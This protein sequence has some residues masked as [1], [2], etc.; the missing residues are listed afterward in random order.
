M[1]SVVP[2][3][4]HPRQLGGGAFQKTGRQVG[5]GGACDDGGLCSG[6]APLACV[7]ELDANRISEPGVVAWVSTR[8]RQ[9]A[10]GYNHRF[11]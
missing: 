3:A 6:K 5:G 1:R 4:S 9:A 7:S 8:G 10:I 2:A 11:G